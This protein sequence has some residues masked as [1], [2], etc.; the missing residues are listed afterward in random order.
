MSAKLNLILAITDK[1]RVDY[2]NLVV[3]YTKFFNK[4]TGSFLGEQR[5]YS[6]K[7]GTIDEPTKRGVK[8]VVTTVNE[9]L[10]YFVENSTDFINK[11]FS[12]ERTNAMGLAK[13]NLIV[14]GITWGEY[15]SLELLRLKSLL[16]ST[17]LGKLQEMLDNIPVRSDSEIWYKSNNEEYTGREIY[18][19]VLVAGV[20]KTTVKTEYILE[21][22]NVSK[23]KD[24]VNY[25]PQKS[26]RN[27]VMEL[28]DYT[29]QRFTGE[30]SHRERAMTL[31]RRSKLLT[32]V[33]DALKRANEVDTVES[34]LTANK[35][36]GYLFYGK[37]TQ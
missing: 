28:G 36:F 19:T 4:S 17:E 29:M 14:D 3:D 26:I 24:N 6:P 21:D 25:I 10:E 22:P 30:W 2:K 37:N 12:Q 9:K 13:A 20:A 5:T 31:A 11:L 32:S 7:E 16:E 23:L 18:E 35:I 33:I 34:T 15:T 27:D 1:L 8:M